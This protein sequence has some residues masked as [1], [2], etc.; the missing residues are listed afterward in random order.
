MK[1]DTKR[2][3][4]EWAMDGGDI[5]AIYNEYQH[6]GNLNSL[7]FVN[8]E[9]GVWALESA[10]DTG[11]LDFGL[12]LP[13][14]VIRDRLENF[15]NKEVSITHPFVQNPDKYRT[16]LIDFSMAG[17]GKAPYNKSDVH[18]FLE[19][20]KSIC[21]LDEFRIFSND[22]KQ[23]SKF[24]E[25]DTKYYIVIMDNGGKVML[26]IINDRIAVFSDG[27]IVKGFFIDS[28]KRLSEEEV[29]NIEPALEAASIPKAIDAGQLYTLIGNNLA[30]ALIG[31]DGI[32]IMDLP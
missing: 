16:L 10:L 29:D 9:D 8:K 4:E 30:D 11:E 3:L 31:R 19:H 12:P 32:G 17:G 23:T 18:E 22:I 13:K 27:Q 20:L 21:S 28:G 5:N 2:A 25:I 26:Y 1:E 24:D 14:E 7:L 6:D 15:C